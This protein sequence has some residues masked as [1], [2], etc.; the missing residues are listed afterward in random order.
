MFMTLPAMPNTWRWPGDFS[1]R[2]WS[3]DP[4]A[5]NEDRLD[6]LHAN[7]QIPKII[8]AARIYELTGEDY[9]HAVAENFWN[10]SPSGTAR[11]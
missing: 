11:M 1:H 10:W 8:G 6:G 4:L 9:Y 2:T 5:R 7:T 3:C